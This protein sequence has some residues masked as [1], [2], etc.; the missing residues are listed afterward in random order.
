MESGG[1][2]M[3][4]TEKEKQQRKKYAAAGQRGQK[5]MSIRIDNDLVEWLNQ[6]RNKGRY[7][8]DLIR[9]DKDK[10]TLRMK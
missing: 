2:N 9:D 6:Q 3:S 1:F 5:M 4:E 7:I 8:N 10:F